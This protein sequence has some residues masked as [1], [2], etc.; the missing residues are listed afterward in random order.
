MQVID[1]N[2]DCQFLIDLN[3]HKYPV[4][5][6]RWNLITSIRDLQHYTNGIKPHRNWKI[7]QVKK[8]FGIKGNKDLIL[9]KLE[10]INKIM[11]EAYSDG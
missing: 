6:G 7:G 9:L 1:M 10:T 5:R 2:T 11:K 3:D 8:Y 4:N